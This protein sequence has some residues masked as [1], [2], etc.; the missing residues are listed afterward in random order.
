[1]RGR[2][3]KARAGRRTNVIPLRV[4][5]RSCFLSR[6]QRNQQRSSDIV[7]SVPSVLWRGRSVSSP[8]LRCWQR[9]MEQCCQGTTADH[10]PTTHPRFVVLPLPC[11]V[12]I[13]AAAGGRRRRAAAAAKAAAAVVSRA[14]WPCAPTPV[15]FLACCLTHRPGPRNVVARRQ[16]EAKNMMLA[17][18]LD[19]SARTRRACSRWWS[20]CLLLPQ[21]ACAA[22]TRPLSSCAVPGTPQSM[23]SRWSS[24]RRPP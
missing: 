7:Q 6:A 4:A 5:R 17:S 18:I 11:R 22:L 14:A 23:A 12:G 1:M 24:R 3:E 15:G 16:E 21:Q 8:H 9:P 20:V 13:L 19:M 10:S 2:G